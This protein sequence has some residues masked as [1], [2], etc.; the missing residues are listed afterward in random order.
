MVATPYKK[1][2]YKNIANLH[3]WQENLEDTRKGTLPGGAPWAA[4][5]APRH[6]LSPNPPGPVR[7]GRRFF[8]LILTATIIFIMMCKYFSANSMQVPSRHGTAC[9]LRTGNVQRRLPPK[10]TYWFWT[11]RRHCERVVLMVFSFAGCRLFVYYYRLRRWRFQRFFPA[12]HA[13]R[14]LRQ[15]EFGKN[16]LPW[17]PLFRTASEPAATPRPFRA[18][19]KRD[20]PQQNPKGRRRM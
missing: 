3:Y 16:W 18:A 11:I 9:A 12:R 19:A 8:S 10:A 20:F 14:A 6:A 1:N 2:C 4:C 5:A 17:K 7:R 13:G 15:K